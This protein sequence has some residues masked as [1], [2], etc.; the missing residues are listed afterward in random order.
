MGKTRKIAV[1][2]VA[3]IVGYSR[4]AGTDEDRTLSRLRGLRT[5]LIDPP[6]RRASRVHRLAD[7]RLQA[8]NQ[9]V[10][11]GSQSAIPA[12]HTDRRS[13]QNHRRR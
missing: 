6:H 7:P 9:S 10:S 12:I 13:R 5:N 3:N 1:I 2:L 11:R 8:A 4:L